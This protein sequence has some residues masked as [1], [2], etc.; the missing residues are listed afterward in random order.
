MGGL[1]KIREPKRARIGIYSA[2]LNTYWDQFAGLYECL[3]GYNRFI[4]EQLSD[5]G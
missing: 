4:A 2:G 5:F 3:M 1:Q